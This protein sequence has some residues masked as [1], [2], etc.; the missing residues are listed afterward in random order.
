MTE[1]PKR[2]RKLVEARELPP[3]LVAALAV[4][5]EQ[6]VQVTVEVVDE[7]PHR[8]LREIMNSMGA[9]AEARGL[10]PELLDEIINAP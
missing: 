8:E 10:T 4:A 9:Q 5:P 2:I 7:D 1:H 6:K 3:A